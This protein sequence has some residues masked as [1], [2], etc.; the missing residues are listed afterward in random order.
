[1]TTLTGNPPLP[2]RLRS[3]DSPTSPTEGRGMGWRA[4]FWPASICSSRFAKSGSVTLLL[5][6]LCKF[7]AG[8]QGTEMAT[9]VRV[10]I[11]FRQTNNQRAQWME[12]GI[13]FH[14]RHTSQ[15]AA[16]AIAP[17][18]E[19]RHTDST[20]LAAMA[21]IGPAPFSLI[22]AWKRVAEVQRSRY[23]RVGFG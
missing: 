7:E 23:R 9:G 15:T 19:A 17:C 18:Q 14:I 20:M 3:S 12:L 22:R 5:R 6:D 8:R 10:M 13:R 4:I 1:M 21:F 16:M 2:V 11:S